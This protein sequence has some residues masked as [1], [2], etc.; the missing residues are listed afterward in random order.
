MAKELES[1]KGAIHAP[2]GTEISCKGWQQEAALRCLMNVL[3]PDVAEDPERLIVYSSICRAARTWKDYDRIVETLRALENNETLVIQSGKPVGVYETFEDAPRVLEVTGFISPEYA[4]HKKFR[5]LEEMGLT[6]SGGFTAASWIYIG[7][8]G[9]IQGTYETMAV[10]AREAFNLDYSLKGKLVLTS[11]LGGMGRAQPLAITMLGGVGI[12][13]EVDKTRIERSIK[14]DIKFL[15]TWTDNLDEALRMAEE[16]KQKEAPLSIG[17]LANAADIYPEFVKRGIVPD[18]V[19]DQTPADEELYGYV[20]AG[21]PFEEAL[22]L[23]Y[24]DPDRYIKMSFASMVKHVQ[25]MND[26]QKMGAVVFEYGNWIRKQA[27]RGGL[28]DAYQFPGFIDGYIRPLFCQGRGPFRWVAVSGYPEDIY[29]TDKAVAE[30]F[31]RLAPWIRMAQQRIP[32]QGLPARICWLGHGE[33]TEFGLYVNELIRKGEIKAPIVFGRDHLDCGSVASPDKQTMNMKDGSDVIG[34]WPILKGLLTVATGASW[35]AIHSV[36][37]MFSSGI[38]IAA[39][40]T[41]KMKARL[42]KTLTADTGLGV[43][44]LADAGYD[45]AIETIK[46]QP[47]YAPLA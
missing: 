5:E 47:F 17:L 24:N 34:D 37:T 26:L 28:K 21:I 25:A 31:P 19:S 16:A 22:K 10:V 11:G 32:F 39:D 23:R 46:D 8:Q 44:R 12:V 33:R 4:T 27:Q 15:D 40:G 45:I 30:L 14:S 13:I 3:D 36:P 42:R 20:P 9:I 1:R 41:E 2:R 7:A 43:T 38:C 35:M 6:M 18:I 29:R